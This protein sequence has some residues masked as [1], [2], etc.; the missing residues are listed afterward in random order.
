MATATVL[1]L[2]LR[3][4]MDLIPMLRL[5]ELTRPLTPPPKEQTL[6]RR[7]AT[8]RSPILKVRPLRLTGR[9]HTGFNKAPARRSWIPALLQSTPV[10]VR[11]RLPTRF[12]DQA[13]QRQ[14]TQT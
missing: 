2:P 14:L 9:I 13:E 8:S 5:L 11:K 4:R 6:F 3:T 7:L 10:R 12:Q 1:K